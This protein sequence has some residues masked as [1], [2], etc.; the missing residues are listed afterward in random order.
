L[1]EDGETVSQI[2][3]IE[4][5]DFPRLDALPSKTEG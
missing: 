2:L 5:Y 1:S 4:D 3:A